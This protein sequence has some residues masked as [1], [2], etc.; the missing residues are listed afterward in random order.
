MKLTLP[1]STFYLIEMP[2]HLGFD[3]VV[4]PQNAKE[5]GRHNVA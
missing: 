3:L 1:R 4:R 5:E 2:D